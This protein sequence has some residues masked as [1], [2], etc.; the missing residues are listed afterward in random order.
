MDGSHTLWTD[1][2]LV[3]LLMVQKSCTGMVLKTRRKSWGVNGVNYQPQ[4][5]SLMDFWTINSITIPFTSKKWQLMSSP[6]LF[7]FRRMRGFSSNVCSST[8][9]LQVF[10][11][12]TTKGED[13]LWYQWTL[14]LSG[15]ENQICSQEVVSQL[16]ARPVGILFLACQVFFFRESFGFSGWLWKRNLTLNFPMRCTPLV[17]GGIVFWSTNFEI[18]LKAWPLS[19]W[20][21]PKNF[22]TFDGS[23]IGKSALPDVLHVKFLKHLLPKIF[24]NAT[25]RTPGDDVVEELRRCHGFDPELGKPG[26]CKNDGWTPLLTR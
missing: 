2:S 23:W 21:N 20:K 4:L 12:L 5:V 3:I 26:W 13:G 14:N 9:I 10:S 7:L 25:F 19:G 6:S 16:S 17:V 18:S 15:L 22:G 11:F 1:L 24:G 8:G